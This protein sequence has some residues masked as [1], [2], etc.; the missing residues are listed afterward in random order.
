MGCNQG[1]LLHCRGV[2]HSLIMYVQDTSSRAQLEEGKE[3]MT[4]SGWPFSNPC[5]PPSGLA[6]YGV[7]WPV[8]ARQL[9]FAGVLECR[10]VPPHSR[11]PRDDN[12]QHASLV[13]CSHHK[14]RVRLHV[15]GQETRHDND[16]WSCPCTWKLYSVLARCLPKC[17]SKEGTVILLYYTLFVLSPFQRLSFFSFSF[18]FSLLFIFLVVFLARGVCV[19]LCSPG[20]NHSG[21]GRKTPQASTPHA[22]QGGTRWTSHPIPVAAVASEKQWTVAKVHSLYHPHWMVPSSS[23][24]T[25]ALL[26]R[27]E[28]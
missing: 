25:F 17:R 16:R 24:N 22:G 20:A 1:G 13:W 23:S 5:S 18:F 2:I 6:W 3:M 11:L 12:E 15:H 27:L 7:V 19:L 26:S 4:K 14:P 10:S 8:Q 21:G 9:P 28:E